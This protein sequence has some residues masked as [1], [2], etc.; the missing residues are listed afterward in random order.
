MT[1]QEQAVAA[2]AAPGDVRLALG[3][4]VVFLVPLA[5]AGAP[6]LHLLLAWLAVLVVYAGLLWLFGLRS[7]IEMGLGVFLLAMN[8]AIG[9]WAHGR[10][11][12]SAGERARDRPEAESLTDAAAPEI[13]GDRAT[14][15][16]GA[17]G[18]WRL[19]AG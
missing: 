10:E 9:L 19:T 15:P 6:V 4:A 16:S 5:L 13:S 11:V 3:V 1:E 7:A 8:V 18:P 17:R 14:T 12:S 2:K